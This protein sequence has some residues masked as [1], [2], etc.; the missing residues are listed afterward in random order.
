M[1]LF[2]LH[3]YQFPIIACFCLFIA[4]ISYW[5]S[6]SIPKNKVSFKIGKIGIFLS[7]FLFIITLLSRWIGEGYFP[8]S[9]LYESLIFLTWSI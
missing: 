9:N 1:K 7:N 6:L 4:M 2:L 3:D 8:L 5:I